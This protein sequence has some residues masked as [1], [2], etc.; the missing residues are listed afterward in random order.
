MLVAE[1]R[2]ETERACSASS[3]ASRSASSGSADAIT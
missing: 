1:A 2:V 3:N